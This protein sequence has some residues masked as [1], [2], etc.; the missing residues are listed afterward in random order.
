M[1]KKIKYFFEFLIIY[2]ISILLSLLPI[3]VVSYLGGSIFKFFGPFTRSNII[4]KKNY[5]KIFPKADKKIF[6]KDILGSWDN[7]GKTIFELLI[8]PKIIRNSK[9]KIKI[10]GNENIKELISLKK[11]C[12][13]VGIH[14]S[15][16]ELIVPTI[17]K[18]G[19]NVSAVYRHIN[20]PYIDNLVL[21]KRSKSIFRKKSHYTPKGKKSAID[22]IK[23]AKNNNSI[24][25][26]IDQKDSAG[27]SIL[28]FGKKVKTQTGFLKIAKKNN[29]SIVPIENTRNGL[30]NFTLKF[31]K[32]IKISETNFNTVNEMQKIHIIIEEWI[33]KN[34][35]NWFLQHNR[36]G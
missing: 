31:H 34:P 14:Q 3:N 11:N 5:L 23:A 19:F 26:I 30:N 1:N 24:L 20:N 33:K 15:N 28:F 21:K 13:F 36:F 18:L 8:L 2:L 6:K 35:S 27:E 32:S 22:I 12:I 29:M 7:L 25:V 10:E 4:A 16:W 9:N 17:D